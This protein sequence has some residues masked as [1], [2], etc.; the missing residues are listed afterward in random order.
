MKRPVMGPTMILPRLSSVIDPAE[1]KV[2]CSRDIYQCAMLRI[3]LLVWSLGWAG[4]EVVRGWCV[5]PSMLLT[6]KK[7]RPEPLSVI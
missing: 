6:K 2:A 4:I 5:M 7:G 1:S 3:T